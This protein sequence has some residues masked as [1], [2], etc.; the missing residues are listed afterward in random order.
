MKGQPVSGFYSE[1][2]REEEPKLTAIYINSEGATIRHYGRMQEAPQGSVAIIYVKGAIMKDDY[3]GNPG[4]D[5]I[6]EQ[7]KL[8]D[9]NENIIGAVHV[10]DSP[11]GTVS[12]TEKCAKIVSLTKKPVVGFV[13]DLSA[14]A[15]YW[16]LSG[17]NHIMM[18]GNTSE[19]GS[20]GTMISFADMRPAYEKLGVKFHDILATKSKDKNKDYFDMLKGSYD[21]VVKNMLDPL[22]EV[23]LS[24]VKNNRPDVSE[25]ALTGKMFLPAEAIA[26]GLADSIGTLEDA[27]AK[28]IELAQADEAPAL[29]GKEGAEGGSALKNQL[30][31]NLEVNNKNEMFDSKLD[32]AVAKV[33][34]KVKAGEEVLKEDVA[35]VNASLEAEGLAGYAI[36]K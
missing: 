34:A 26:L 10:H 27:V 24:S 11:G 29:A 21:D 2:E 18:S 5:S 6:G 9:G 30:L 22:N 3:C 28:V 13:D 15:S 19:V 8:A 31:K 36:T 32:K 12:G 23:F 14:S 7:I 17:T 4:T 35:P 33:S 20:I 16:I 1:D 25:E